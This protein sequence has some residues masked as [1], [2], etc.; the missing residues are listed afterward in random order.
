MHA[1]LEDSGVGLG[2]VFD[3]A[4]GA[5]VARVEDVMKR[6]SIEQ[7]AAWFAR[8]A[9]GLAVVWALA[10]GF[11]RASTGLGV[12][13]TVGRFIAF[14]LG[15]GI[16]Y[17]LRAPILA[18]LLTWLAGFYGFWLLFTPVLGGAYLAEGSVVL[19]ERPIEPG[20]IIASIVAA[21]LVWLLVRRYRARGW[22]VA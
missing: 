20:R 3:L 7:A 5:L 2:A 10:F 16:C 4:R 8:N 1:L 11:I 19:Y 17:R 13:S 14:T 22:G 15:A 18:A 21:T 12:G 6:A 9:L